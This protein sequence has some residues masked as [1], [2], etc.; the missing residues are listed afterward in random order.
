MIL[1]EKNRFF[2]Y[3]HLFLVSSIVLMITIIAS[4]QLSTLTNTRYI[5]KEIDE[6]RG[7]YTSLF[8]QG[9]GQGNCIVLE[10]QVGYT[11]FELM[12]YIDDNVTKR[13]IEYSIQTPKEYFDISGQKIEFD[14]NGE[15]IYTTSDHNL[16]VK[17]VWG[18]PQVVKPNTYKYEYEVLTNTGEP[19]TSIDADYKFT[20]QQNG[21][22][23]IGKRHAVSIKA[24]RKAMYGNELDTIEHISIVINLVKP[25]KDVYI[26][27]MV[28]VNRLIAFTN[29]ETSQFD[30][31][32][33]TLNIQTADIFTRDIKINENTQKITSKAFKVTLEWNNLI[34]DRRELGLLHNV[35]E[36]DDL[37]NALRRSNQNDLEASNIDISKSYLISLNYTGDGISTGKLELYVPQSSGFSIDF[38]P[39]SSTYSVYAKVELLDVNTNP[40]TPSYTLYDKSYGGYYDDELTDIIKGENVEK[41]I[42]VLG[43]DKDKLIH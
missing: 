1:K 21:T 2:N 15:P 3:L 29:L 25:Y 7:Y 39:V 4:T 42:Y 18:N 35:V 40:S 43:N 14:A 20:Y 28:V 8:F 36:L 23:G 27:D 37:L 30:A 33:Q 9:T 17:D 31:K 26:I 6:V 19:S 38:F 10:N 13:D 24:T 12:N 41:M 11:S 5:K 34:I 16:Y 32:F 22:T